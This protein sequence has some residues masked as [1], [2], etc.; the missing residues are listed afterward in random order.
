MKRVGVLL[1]CLLLCGLPAAGS[2]AAQ[3]EKAKGGR[4]DD[5]SKLAGE[6]SGE[7][8][9]ADREK[10]PACNDERVIYR[11]APAPGRPD[12]LTITMDK[13]VNGKPETMAVFDFAYD[14][15]ARTLSA[16]FT[17]NN[18]RG[19]WEFAVKGDL[20]EGTLTTLPDRT[21]VRRIRVKKDE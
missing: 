21:L 18:R 15:R 6:W 12:T 8:V 5:V 16:E 14:A 17:R 1:G 19:V 11:V 7:S 2:T 13:V 4:G 9:C 20:L 10:F 3:G